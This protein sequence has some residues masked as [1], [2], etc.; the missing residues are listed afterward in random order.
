MWIYS[1]LATLI[2]GLF[3]A[4]A[5]EAVYLRE[6]P[7]AGVFGG[8]TVIAIVFVCLTLMDW[9]RCRRWAKGASIHEG[10]A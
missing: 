7:L 3:S 5:L 8:L 2:A 1:I 10:D 9:V 4:I 6:Y